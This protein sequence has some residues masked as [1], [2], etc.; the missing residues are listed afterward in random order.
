[1]RNKPRY[2]KFP[3]DRSQLTLGDIRNLVEQSI[4]MP[5]LLC[6]LCKVEPTLTNKPLLGCEPL[7]EYLENK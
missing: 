5:I 4:E 7:P 6:S 2:K 1:M 3:T